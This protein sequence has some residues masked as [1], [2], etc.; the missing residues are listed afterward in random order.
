MG[1]GITAVKIFRIGTVFVT[2]GCGCLE[3]VDIEWIMKDGVLVVFV[4]LPV[5]TRIVCTS[6]VSKLFP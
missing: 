2:G 1:L 3:A 4:E 5:F 6:R